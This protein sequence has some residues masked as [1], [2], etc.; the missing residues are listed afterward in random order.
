MEACELKN[1]TKSE[2]SPKREVK[3]PTIQNVDFLI[4][5]GEAIFS[6]FPNVNAHDIESNRYLNYPSIYE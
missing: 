4:R 2:K 6:F 5:G 1:V 3:K